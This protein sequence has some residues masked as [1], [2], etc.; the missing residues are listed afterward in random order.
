MAEIARPRVDAQPETDAAARARAARDRRDRILTVASPIGLLAAWEAAAQLGLIDTRF[1]PAPSSILAALWEMLLSGELAENVGV[2]LQRLFWGFL[3]G[4]IP[5]LALGILMGLYRPLRAVVDPLIAAT[6]PIPKS[7]IL[8]LIL[9]IFGLGEM[10]KVVMVAIGAFYPI[11]I[12]ATAGVLEI[13][14]VYIDVGKSFKAGRWDT[15]RT[16]AFPGA[17]PFIMTGVKLG[18]GLALILIAIAEMVGAKSGL[19]FLVWSAWETFSVERMYV[20]L[21]AIAI[22]GFALTLMLNEVER[23]LIPWKADR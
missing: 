1:F 8:P 4:A 21:F 14:K 3:L 18:A 12:N 22:I 7:A 23:W 16:I 15:F 5:G 17:L 2:S 6:Y 11:V 13:G 10:S 19:G 20:G 9:L